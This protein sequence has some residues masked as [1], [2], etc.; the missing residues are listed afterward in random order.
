MEWKV[1]KWR[2]K[3]YTHCLLLSP[4]CKSSLQ[5]TLACT[6][7]QTDWFLPSIIED[8]IIPIYGKRVTEISFVNFCFPN[9]YIYPLLKTILKSSRDIHERRMYY[10]INTLLICFSYKQIS[11]Y[12]LLFAKNHLEPKNS[13][14]HSIISTH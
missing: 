1:L 13:L 12:L 14:R 9:V 4:H 3:R 7:C 6:T 2:I 10:Y 8:R 5:H 11:N